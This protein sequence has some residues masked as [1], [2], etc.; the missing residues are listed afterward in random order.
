MRSDE[1]SSG[2]EISGFEEMCLIRRSAASRMLPLLVPEDGV[3]GAAPRAVLD[4]EPPVAELEQLAVAKRPGHLRLGAPGRKLPVTCRRAVTTSS[5]ILLMPPHEYG[6][7]LVVSLGVIAEVLD[8]GDEKVECR[9]LGARAFPDDVDQSE[10]VDVLVGDDHQLD[11]L[12][13]V[14]ERL[15]LALELVQCLA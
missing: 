5:E 12:D 7:L 15:E 4:L 1:P 9:D 11:V 8:E 2:R 3:R 10:V 6:R 14:A 13:P